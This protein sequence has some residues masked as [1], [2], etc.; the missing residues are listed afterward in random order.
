MFKI[1]ITVITV[2]F[3]TVG[4]SKD[5][6]NP[7][8]EHKEKQE[9]QTWEYKGIESEN[10][11]SGWVLPSKEVY[12]TPMFIMMDGKATPRPL[13]AG[14]LLAAFVGDV[15]HGVAE[16]FTGSDGYTRFELKVDLFEDEKDREDLMVELRF[17]SKQYSRLFITTPFPFEEGEI[18]GGYQHSY[19][20]Q[21]VK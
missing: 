19:Q 10:P 2:L 7:Q 1:F 6:V 11:S 20:P 14:D 5:D 12:P 8:D 15:C 3:L 9:E 16:A 4:C 17:Y 21:W 13:A 18:K